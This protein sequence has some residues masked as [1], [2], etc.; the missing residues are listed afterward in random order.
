MAHNLA[1]IVGTIALF[2]GMIVL[3]FVFD[4]AVA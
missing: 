4:E 3:M 2:I 1:D